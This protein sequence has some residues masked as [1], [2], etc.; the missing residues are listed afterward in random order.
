MNLLNWNNQTFALAAFF[1]FSSICS[2]AQT[3]DKEKPTAVA[4]WKFDNEDTRKVAD[5]VTSIN[6]SI[7][8]NF[9]LVKGI[10]GRALKFDGFTTVIRRSSD[11]VPE[12]SGSLTFEAWVAAATYPWNWC[13]LLAQEKKEEAGFYFGVGPQ[14]QAGIFASV[15]GVWQRCETEVKIPQ[16]SGPICLPALMNMQDLK[17]ISMGTYLEN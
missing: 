9:S 13:P 3:D 8:G 14:G 6:D 17:Y 4:W 12:L 5:H 2:I 11:K 10:E 16:E 7:E 1:I 15:D